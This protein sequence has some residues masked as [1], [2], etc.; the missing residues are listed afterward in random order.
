MTYVIIIIKE[1]KM[2]ILG[3]FF[4]LIC[5][6]VFNSSLKSWSYICLNKLYFCIYPIVK[7]L[8]IAVD[9][10]IRIL[11]TTLFVFHFLKKMGKQEMGVWKSAL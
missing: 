3:Q 6:R 1:Y 8:A 2:K 10:T 9:F 7:M 5:Y 4:C 11:A